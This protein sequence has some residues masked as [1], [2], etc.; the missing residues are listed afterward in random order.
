MNKIKNPKFFFS[1]QGNKRKELN[2]LNDVINF[3][4]FDNIIDLFCGSCSFW[5]YAEKRNNNKK[6]KYICNDIWQN[7]IMFLKD[8]K[9]N[10]IDKYINEANNIN[11]EMNEEKYNIMKK[12]KNNNLYEYYYISN[13]IFFNSNVNPFCKKY[14]DN[15]RA[16]NLRKRIFKKTKDNEEYEKFIKNDNVILLNDDFENVF[17]EYWNNKQNNLFFFDPPYY[18]SDKFNNQ[19]GF[20]I[21]K[22]D[23]V[24]NVYFDMLQRFE[25]NNKCLAILENNIFIEKLM[26]K[27]VVKKYEF[28]YINNVFL[29]DLNKIQ[30]RIVEHVI[31]KNF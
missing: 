7:L 14:N 22:K 10:N 21:W 15:N 5:L 27:Y 2:N 18:E 25:S 17:N 4:E 23:V 3:E 9:S 30:K 12:N 13:I 24:M 31:L 8:V 11:K 6:T 19:Y 16:L 29:S 28:K 20:R 26:K 1:Y